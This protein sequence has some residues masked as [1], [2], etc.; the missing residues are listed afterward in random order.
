MK[1][2]S[3]VGKSQKVGNSWNVVFLY[4][5]VTAAIIF[6]AAGTLNWPAAWL[7]FGIGLA[8]LVVG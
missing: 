1:T 3:L 2:C 4:V 5:V 6:L 7:Y 8:A